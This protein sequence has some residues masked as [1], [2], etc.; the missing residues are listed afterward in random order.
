MLLYNYK[1]QIVPLNLPSSFPPSA[2]AEYFLIIPIVPFPIADILTLV[3][4]SV[5]SP[6]RACALIQTRK[7]DWTSYPP[8]GSLS[9]LTT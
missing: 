2:L 7:I 1:T 9:Y 3:H 5:L 8:I 6:G 4:M